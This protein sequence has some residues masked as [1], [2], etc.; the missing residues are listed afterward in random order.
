MECILH[1]FALMTNLNYHKKILIIDQNFGHLYQ[2]RELL[3][4]AGFQVM[5]AKDPETA[6][7]LMSVS[8]FDYLIT[9]LKNNKNDG[10]NDGDKSL[11][12]LKEIVAG[13]II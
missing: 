2:F 5:T 6:L 12:I 9:N 4:K 11:S 7:K 8:S 1:A 3:S 13:K 10:D